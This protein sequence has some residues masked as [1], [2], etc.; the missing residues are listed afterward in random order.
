MSPRTSDPMSR[1]LLLA[2]LLCLV[3]LTGCATSPATAPGAVTL[4]DGSRYEGE[5][6]D[7]LFDGKGTLSATDGARYEGEFRRG[8]YHGRGTYTSVG[9]DVYHGDFAEGELTGQ[10]RISYANGSSWEGEVRRWVPEGRGTF[11]LASGRRYTGEF[12]G[13]IPAG[14]VIV[15]HETGTRYEGGMRGWEAFHGPGVFTGGGAT[16]RGTFEN[17]RPIGVFSVE[18]ENSERYTGTIRNRDYHGEGRL[19]RADGAIYTGEFAF[20]RFHGAGTLEYVD[21]AGRPRTVSGRFERGLYTGDDADVYV[22]DGIAR[23]DGER[24]LFDQPRLLGDA[25]RRLAPQRPG[26][27][28]LYFVAFGSHGSEDVFM[29]EVRHAANVMAD[30]FSAGERT[31]ELVNNPATAHDTPLASV[32]NLRIALK[33]VGRRMD[34]EEDVLFLYLTSHG[35]EGHELSVQLDGVPLRG[36]S[37]VELDRIIADSGIKWKIVLVSACFSGGFI[38]HLRDDHTLVMTSAAADRTSFG[39]S[40]DSE[41]TWFGRAYFADALATGESLPDAFETARDLVTEWEARDDYMPSNPQ[42]HL[43]R[44][45]AA[46]LE[47]LGRDPSPGP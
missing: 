27:P 24:I 32:T 22:R 1:L 35:S 6:R 45:I 11:V 4:P 18:R 42:I 10:A 13:G 19:V 41:L 26:I 25:L 14:Q 17:G 33:E 5:L 47:A 15:E 31:L 16:Y 28:D 9:G 8:R 43:P 12:S 38:E 34:V 23:L 37:A 44:P 36:L 21:A 46:K 40:N 39:C 20:G 3:M 7:G 2:P 30:R 29:R